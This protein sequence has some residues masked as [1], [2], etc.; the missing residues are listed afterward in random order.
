MNLSTYSDWSKVFD[1]I[2]TWE[3]GHVDENL[4]ASI[5]NGKIEWLDGVAQ[6]MTLRLTELI[7]KRSNKLNVFYNKRLQAS[8][9]AFDI[10][11]LLI[12]FR[13]ELIFLKRLSNIPVLPD[14]LKR[15]LTTEIVNY[16]NKT[17]QAL[18][19]S[20]KHDLSGEVKRVILSYKINNI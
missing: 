17:Q 4:M 3:I 2:D 7:N 20:V 8:Y 6:R 11:N 5:E 1:E 18:E 16:A 12:T 15:S 10:S 14:E 9:N 19:D 13:K